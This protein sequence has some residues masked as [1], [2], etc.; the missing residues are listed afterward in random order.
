MARSASPQSIDPQALAC[1]SQRTARRISR[2]AVKAIVSTA[3]RHLRRQRDA[4][5]RPQ[6]GL[7][8]APD[9]AALIELV[10][11][12]VLSPAMV[13]VFAAEVAAE[14]ARGSAAPKAT[15]ASIKRKLVTAEKEIANLVDAIAGYGLKNNLDVQRRLKAATDARDA[16]RLETDR[17]DTGGTKSA[18]ITATAADLSAM[19]D[20]LVRGQV[21]ASATLYKARG[22]LTELVDPFEAFPHE[23]DMEFRAKL[24]RLGTRHTTPPNFM[25]PRRS[26]QIVG[27][28]VAGGRF[29]EPLNVDLR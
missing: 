6:A 21:D 3:L 25:I 8:Q 24:R 20:K 2:P 23:D 12:A 10:K 22:L 27:N 15:A 1:V 29:V 13:K 4:G 19:L 11:K 5:Q 18:A 17:L 16:A 26:R 9:N 14:T 7:Q 28:L